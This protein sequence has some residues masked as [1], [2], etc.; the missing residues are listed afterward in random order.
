MSILDKKA[1][2]ILQEAR[3]YGDEKY[4]VLITIAYILIII[5]NSIKLY[6]LCKNKDEELFHDMKN[7]GFAQK[8]VLNR[9]I[10]KHI[11]EI[12]RD[13]RKKLLNVI[14]DKAKELEWEEFIALLAEIKK[15]V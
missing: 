15:V 8:I 12:S 13:G 4:G 7:I 11:P 3:Q 14:V 6:R 2:E 10:K 9:Q 5:V 1:N